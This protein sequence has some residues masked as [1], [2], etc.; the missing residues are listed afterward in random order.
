M[1]IPT[2]THHPTLPTQFPVRAVLW[3]PTHQDSLWLDNSNIDNKRQVDAILLDFTKALDKVPHK[4]LI[5]IN[6]LRNKWKYPKLNKNNFY[7]SI[8][9]KNRGLR[10]QHLLDNTCVTFGVPYRSVLGP[11]LFLLCRN[12]INNNIQPP[13]WLY[14]DDSIIYRKITSETDTNIIQS[15]LIK[16]QTWSNKW[17]MEFNISKCVHLPVTNKIKPS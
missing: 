2:R 14:A 7:E 15:D 16:L 3:I 8:C 9:I 13:I 5:K 10:Q 17:Q 12:D 6:L 1:E 4:H 11:V